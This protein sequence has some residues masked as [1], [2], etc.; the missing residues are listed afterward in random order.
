MTTAN[1]PSK[2]KSQPEPMN[3]GFD[4]ADYFKG[5]KSEFKQVS[6]PPRQQVIAETIMAIVI[7]LIFTVIIYL[8]DITLAG[9]IH[10]VTNFN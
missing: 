10:L 4:F 1:T 7:V 6:W 9:L 3:Q 8:I 5:V 2:T